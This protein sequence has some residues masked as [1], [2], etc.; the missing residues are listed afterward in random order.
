MTEKRQLSDFIHGL[1][2]ETLFQVCSVNLRLVF[3]EE[4]LMRTFYV[5]AILICLFTFIPSKPAGADGPIRIGLTLGLTGKY[6]YMSDMQLKGFKLWQEDVNSRGGILGREIELTIY[7]DKSNPR[8]ATSIYKQLVLNDRVDLLFGPYSSEITEAILPITEK[9]GYPLLLSG[10]S[11]DSLWQKGYKHV[12]GIF[13]SASKYVVGFLELLVM[14]DFE[15]ISIVYADD[16][17]SKGLAAGTKK[18]A[19]RFGLKVILFERFKKGKRN[20]DSI[21]EKLKASRPQVVIVCGHFNEAVDMRLSLKR[22]GWYPQAFYAS[23]GPVMDE[24]YEM[25]G[26]D[27]EYTFSSSQWEPRLNIPGSR[28]FYN[29][30]LKKYGVRPAYHAAEAYAAGQILESAI[31]KAGSLDRDRLGKI[32]SAMDTMSII[33]RYGVDRTGMQTKHFPLIIQWQNGRKE[34][35]WPEQFRTA[36]PIFKKKPMFKSENN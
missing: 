8:I 22:A 11:A 27:A 36:N 5:S 14:N 23:I 10:A 31:K 24:F 15:N 4:T 1:Y 26:F 18:W 25:L 3:L 30:F 29:R 6:S 33:G 7:D 21:T 28:E 16:T 32:L 19:E 35:V 17:F 20:L 34:I 13:T 9:Y 12:F 2:L